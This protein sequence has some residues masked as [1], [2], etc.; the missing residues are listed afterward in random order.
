MRRILS[1]LLLI[2]VALT[3]GVGGV[4]AVAAQENS[5]KT[6]QTSIQA[7]E[8]GTLYLSDATRVTDWRIDNGTA[9]VTLELSISRTVVITDAAA[10]VGTPG[11]TRV[12][13]ESWNLSRG[14]HNLTM[15]VEEVRGASA[16]SISTA[17]GSY[18]L[19]TEMDP[20]D[21]EANPFETFGGESG[22]FWGVGMTVIVAALAA[23]YTIRTEASG[24]VEA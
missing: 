15:S 5:T 4:E 11:A 10:G 3:V 20:E 1:A 16:I 14:T 12:P 9:H 2:A 23:W 17:G 8:N 18:R 7:P 6:S 24:V 19:S 21:D 22:L 13:K